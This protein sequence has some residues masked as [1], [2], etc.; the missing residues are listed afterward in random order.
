M[1]AKVE[2]VFQHHLDHEHL[3]QSAGQE[4]H[5]FDHFCDYTSISGFRFLHTRHP[6]WFRT[7]S[8]I[9]LFGSI[10]MFIYHSSVFVRKFTSKGDMLQLSTTKAD[11]IQIPS[12]VKEVF[13]V[14]VQSML[15][16]IVARSARTHLQLKNFRACTARTLST[17]DSSVNL[18]EVLA[19]KI[20]EHNKKVLAFRKEHGNTPIQQVTIDMVYG[21]MRSIKGMVTETSVLDP[22]EGIRFRG[23]TIPECQ[24]LLPKAP[25]GEEPLPEAIWWLLTTG[26][27]PTKEQ[28]SGISKEW[29]ARG[30]LPD[31]VVHMLEN[32]PSVLHPMS[33]FVAAIAALQ[34]ESKFAKAYSEGVSKA[35]YWEYAYEDSMNLLAKLPTVAAIIYRSLYRDGSPVP[36]ID[37]K[38][39]WSGT[40]APCWATMILNLW[41]CLRAHV[42]PVASAL[43]DPYL[44]FSAG[45][46]GLAGPLHGLANQEVLVFLNKLLKEIGSDYTE[47]SL[48]DWI[49]NHLKGGQ[50]V[51]GYGH[52][53]LRKTDPRF[54]CQQEFAL[55]HLPEDEMFKLVSAVYRVTPVFFWSKAKLRTVA[56]R[57]CSFWSVAAALWNEGDAV[58]HCA[59][60][61]FAGSRCLSQLIWSRG[62][63]LPLE[64]PKSHSTD[65][66]IQLFADGDEQLQQSYSSYPLQPMFDRSKTT[67][68]LETAQGDPSILLE[69]GKAKNPWPTWMLI[70]ECC[71]SIMELKE[72]ASTTLCSLEFAGSRVVF[73]ADMVS[74]QMNGVSPLERPKSHS[75]DGY[76]QLVKA[77]Q[78]ENA[79]HEQ[80]IKTSFVVCTNVHVCEE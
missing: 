15:S 14:L 41:K 57:G 27:I 38:K 8:A 60:W 50:V 24:K 13:V 63:G 12:V 7:V 29:A 77:W 47:Q 21:G 42:S 66:Y 16:A 28:V 3:T 53:V 76:I 26:D 36:V 44:S 61:S 68:E 75:T 80:S 58:L 56:E 64:R 4:K 43:S 72:M 62:M 34:S 33:Q 20:P 25:K 1:E 55:K 9:V 65:G 37:V 46:A 71:C 70:L 6:F 10:G 22:E 30:D 5:I 39:D 2:K 49:W 73:A 45:M 52:A 17:T 18:K 54:T 78:S 79:G 40:F 48:R 19:Q 32:F 23:Y 51:P 59:L 69:Q 67:D 11:A 31:H 74:W 35:S